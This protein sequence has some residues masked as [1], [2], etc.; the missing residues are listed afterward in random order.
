[1]LLKNRYIFFINGWESTGDRFAPAL[2]KKLP[3]TL[4]LIQ[5]FGFGSTVRLI[6]FVN[7]LPSVFCTKN[8]KIH[9]EREVLITTHANFSSVIKKVCIYGIYVF[10]TLKM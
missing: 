8:R 5:I 1:M 4:Q 6:F 3:F 2:S 7:S 10:I 9:S